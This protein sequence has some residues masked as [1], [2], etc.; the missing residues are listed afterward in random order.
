MQNKIVENNKFNKFNSR[1]KSLSTLFNSA[2]RSLTI[3]QKHLMKQYQ[4]YFHQFHFTETFLAAVLPGFFCKDEYLFVFS[5]FQEVT[6]ES[7]EE[8]WN[9]GMSDSRGHF[10]F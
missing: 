1:R 10:N 7:V 4:K 2:I 6:Y 8:N 5:S 9:R 3:C